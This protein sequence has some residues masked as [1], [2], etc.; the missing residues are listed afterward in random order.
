MLRQ[1]CNVLES[2]QLVHSLKG[3]TLAKGP[4][5]AVS[6][7]ISGDLLTENCCYRCHELSDGSKKMKLAP[8]PF[9]PSFRI[10]NASSM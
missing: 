9:K 8:V 2:D 3:T 7:R 10:I 6:S 4:V 5:V 1:T